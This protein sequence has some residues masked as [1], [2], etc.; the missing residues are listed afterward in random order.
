M[1]LQEIEFSDDEL[2]MFESD[3][4]SSDSSFSFSSDS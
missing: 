2:D 1:P 3:S 4:S